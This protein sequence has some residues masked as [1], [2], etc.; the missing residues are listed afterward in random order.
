MCCDI[1]RPILGLISYNFASKWDS[2]TPLEYENSIYTTLHEMGHILGLT[3]S[4][5]DNF[6]NPNT[7][8]K[9]GNPTK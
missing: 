3:P 4:L 8:Q 9:L 5:F 7:G 2:N 6:I 1:V